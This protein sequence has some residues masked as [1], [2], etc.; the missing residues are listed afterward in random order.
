ME[1]NTS[2]VISIGKWQVG[3]KCP[4]CSSE[5]DKGGRL[6]AKKKT[7]WYLKCLRC[8][9]SVS[10]S[11]LQPKGY[12]RQRRDAWLFSRQSLGASAK[13]LLLNAATAKKLQKQ[14]AHDS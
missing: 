6:I 8:K 7:Q 10:Q 5:R 9:W 2:K 11:K 12:E 3:Q 4:A 1:N 14:E 13:K